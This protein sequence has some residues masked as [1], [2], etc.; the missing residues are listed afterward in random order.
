MGFPTAENPTAQPL[1]WFQG[2]RFTFPLLTP[3][4]R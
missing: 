1:Y 3:T 4:P 2:G